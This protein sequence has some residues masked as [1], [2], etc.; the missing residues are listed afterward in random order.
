MMSNSEISSNSKLY[1]W[2]YLRPKSLNQQHN[3][4]MPSVP[5][6]MWSVIQQAVFSSI[7]KATAE[8]GAA[9]S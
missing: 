6:D 2:G 8:V 4:D 1:L 3:C 7:A 9:I 5:K